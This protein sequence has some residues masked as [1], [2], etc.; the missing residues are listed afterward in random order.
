M[1]DNNAGR[2]GWIIHPASHTVSHTQWKNGMRMITS[3]KFNQSPR[4]LQSALWENSGSR[5]REGWCT[6]RHCENYVKLGIGIDRTCDDRN[7]E[8]RIAIVPPRNKFLSLTTPEC[9]FRR[10]VFTFNWRNNLR[11]YD[12]KWKGIVYRARGKRNENGVY[13]EPY[14]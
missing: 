5:S 6:C 8:A 1:Y 9:R 3:A 2:K 12:A 10:N 14:V 11:K 4:E 13:T 7:S